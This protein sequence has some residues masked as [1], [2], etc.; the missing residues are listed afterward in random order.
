MTR[1]FLTS[2]THFGHAGM[3][4]FLRDDGT[5]LR[6]W[7]DVD[8]MNEALIDNWNRV[9]GDKDRVYHLGDVAMNRRFLPILGRLKGRKVL[10]KGNHDIFKLADYTPYLDDIRGCQY[11][12]KLIL[13]HIPIHNGSFEGRYRGNIHGHLHWRQIDDPRYFNACVECTDFT[14]MDFELIRSHY[15]E[16]S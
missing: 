15:D 4:K 14:P 12:D 2:D 9:V 11:L 1:T 3:T 16:Q 6:P 8:E 5:K 13:T 10:I 7:E